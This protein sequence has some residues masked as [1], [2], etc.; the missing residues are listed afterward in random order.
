[1]R[2]EES[3]EKIQKRIRSEKNL[4]FIDTGRKSKEIKS[5]A[6]QESENSLEWNT[7]LSNIKSRSKMTSITWS[8]SFKND[9]AAN[10]ELKLQE[11]DKEW[12]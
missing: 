10:T 12:W 7:K 11:K 8:K 9:P 4:F 5:N 1:M 2:E 6:Q 3:K